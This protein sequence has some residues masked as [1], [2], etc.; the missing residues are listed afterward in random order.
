MLS[1]EALSSAARQLLAIQDVLREAQERQADAALR[2]RDAEAS[3]ESQMSSLREENQ[4][5]RAAFDREASA[6][7]ETEQLGKEEVDRLA[8]L[9]ESHR[10]QLQRDSVDLKRL[11]DQAESLLSDREEL[12]RVLREREKAMARSE[13][14][15]QRLIAELTD[16]LTKTRISNG[17]LA[18][19]LSELQTKLSDTELRLSESLTEGQLLRRD[20][21]SLRDLDLR[22]QRSE[23]R[24]KAEHAEEVSALR[25]LLEEYSGSLAEVKPLI[26]ESGQVSGT[27]RSL[28]FEGGLVQSFQGLLASAESARADAEAQRQRLEAV[29]E[30]AGRLQRALDV[31]RRQVDE[32]PSLLPGSHC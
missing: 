5:L 26:E 8:Q 9:A 30:D 12:S 24:L 17:E 16:S 18:E 31:S 14:T 32:V 13:A 22:R 29:S 28:G 6:R 11:S 21:A 3:H 23:D 15:F 25:S 7:R 2:S 4:A 20:N 10:Q 19:T 1:D 27:L